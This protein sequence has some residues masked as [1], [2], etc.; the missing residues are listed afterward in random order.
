MKLMIIAGPTA[1]LSAVPPPGTALHRFAF[2]AQLGRRSAR[3]AA[4]RR[5]WP[6]LFGSSSWSLKWDRRVVAALFTPDLSPSPLP[7]SL[8]FSS[9]LPSP[10]A[11]VCLGVES[12]P[13]SGHATRSRCGQG[14]GVCS[15]P[16]RASAPRP[17]L[18]FLAR[19][20]ALTDARRA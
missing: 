9:I 1:G 20:P 18:D 7:P 19:G 5:S 13:L 11:S 4:Q 16:D 15:Q 3:P 17:S 14:S 2:T 12:A 6:S 10:G 8:F